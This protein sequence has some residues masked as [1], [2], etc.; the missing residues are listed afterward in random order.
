MTGNMEQITAR[1]AHRTPGALRRR[2]ITTGIA[3]VAAA[4]VVAGGTA[5]IL[6]RHS[7]AS[8]AGG[9]NGYHLPTGPLPPVAHDSLTP[10]SGVLFG[11][12]VKPAAGF[13]DADQESGIRGFERAIGRKLAID[14]LY[15]AWKNPMPMG[16]ANW[17]LKRG[18]IPM[19]SWGGASSKRIL[20]GRY[21]SWIRA[22]AR[23]L[24]SLPG[25]VLL[26]WFPEMNNPFYAKTIGSPAQFIAAWRHVHTIFAQVGAKN[27]HWV[28]NPSGAG[29]ATGSTERFYPGNA[30]VNWIGVD[31]YNWAPRLPKVSWRSFAQI[32]AAFYQWAAHQGKP[33]LVGEFGAVEGKPEAKAAWFRQAGRQLRAEFPR[34][35]AIVY[36][37]SIHENFGVV[38]D[39]K[40]TSSRSSLAAFRAIAHAPYFSA[41]P[42]T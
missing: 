27:V 41:R 13:T 10:S 18:S 14:S 2:L 24:K 31:G 32:F 12:W 5:V 35:R 39:W 23:Q 4:A 21:D 37:N 19:I 15:V 16:L 17:D 36:F 22:E 3:V 25:P 11:A 7:A 9:T 29:F 33:L 26:R 40:V 42:S 28:W 6:G 30:Y 8:S 38:F 1:R 20:A 34:I